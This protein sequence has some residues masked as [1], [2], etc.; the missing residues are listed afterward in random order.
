VEEGDVVD[1][2]QTVAIIEA[3]KIMN[4]VKADRAGRV[5]EIVA[6]DGDWVE[7]QQVVMYLE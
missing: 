4:E 7:F 2:G 6:K 1:S 3:M 5:K